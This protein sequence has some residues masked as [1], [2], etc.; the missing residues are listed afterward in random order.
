FP[1]AVVRKFGDDWGGKHAAL[2][3]YYGFV[4]LFPLLLVFVTVTG[5]V[6]DGDP[7]LQQRLIDTAMDQLPVLG[8]QVQGAVHAIQGSGVGLA[9]GLAGTLWGGLAITQTAQDALNAVWNIPRSQRPNL[10]LRS[11]RSLGAVLVVAALFSATALAGLGAI[12]PDV[13][14]SAEPLAGSL[15][16]NL[17]L[18]LAMF[19]LLTARVAPWAHLIPGAAAG[20]V[21]W[22]ALQ[23]VGV[24]IV[25]RQ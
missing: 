14:G 3:A 16:L 6:L 11:A 13:I 5:Y 12:W 25:N 19:Q 17:L 22:S 15:L 24:A 23:A 18:L 9:V 21:V 4:S 20:A 2:L 8:P 10:W 7:D 1:V